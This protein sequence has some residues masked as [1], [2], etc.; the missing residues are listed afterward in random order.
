MAS[1]TGVPEHNPARSEE[2][3]LL[4][5]PGD[6]TQMPEQGLQF[7]FVTG[8]AIVAQAGAWILAAL[9][10]VCSSLIAFL[11]G[12]QC[13]HD[14]VKSAKNMNAAALTTSWPR[15]ELTILIGCSARSRLHIFQLSSSTTIGRYPLPR[16]SHTSCATDCNTETEKRWNIRTLSFELF[17]RG[18]IGGWNCCDWYVLHTYDKSMVLW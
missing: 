10:W 9:V 8:T 13:R 12:R 17:G 15:Y 18:C 16:P 14:A 3:P 6:A 4:G 7:N 5:R 11:G 1:A 2:E